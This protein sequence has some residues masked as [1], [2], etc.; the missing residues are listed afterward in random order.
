MFR[1]SL[2]VLFF[3]VYLHPSDTLYTI[4]REA[5][6]VSSIVRYGNTVWVSS[7]G[8]G[9]FGFDLEK[10]TTTVFST[11]KKN[12]DNDFFYCVAEAKDYIWAGT[13][14]GLM[15]YDKRRKAWRKRKFSSGGEYG[16]WI[17]SLYFDE[18]SNA[19]WIGRF[20][21]LTRFDVAA[22]KFEDFDITHNNLQGSNNIKV[23]RPES[24]KFLWIGTEAGVFLYDKTLLPSDKSAMRFYSNKGNGF[25]GEGESVSIADILPE[26]KFVWFA[27]EEFITD[28]SPE[29]NLG[30]LFR[31]NR[32]ATWDK[33]DKRNGLKANGISSITRV[34]RYMFASQY[35]FDPKSK[36]EMGRGI[37]MFDRITGKPLRFDP[38]EIKLETN[39]VTQLF[40]DGGNLWIGTDKGLWK[41]KFANAFAEPDFKK[42][43]H[44][45][46]K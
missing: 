45:R 5:G 40:Y 14:D 18:G 31:Y 32:K 27:T 35:D 11:E 16:N 24:D 9:L 8:R 36:A 39:Q 44:V 26:D 10:N 3:A 28:D 42:S 4:Y 20:V 30:G 1:V 13:S 19:L 33:F 2:I 29:F 22:N 43:Q 25:R 17:R 6:E 23:I 21:N 15:I 34:G 38:E 7:Y 12:I 37:S 41:V 46:K